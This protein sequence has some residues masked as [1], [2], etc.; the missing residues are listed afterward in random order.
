[1]SLFPKTGRQHQLRV[2]L[3]ALGFPIVGDKLYGPE[4]EAPFYEALREGMSDELLGRLGHDRQA[5]HA[6]SIELKHPRT[7][8]RLS[9]T[10]P[11]APDLRKLWDSF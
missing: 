11:L 1:M 8:E 4:R 7:G 2:H 10:A 3:S 9:I 5:L 6:H